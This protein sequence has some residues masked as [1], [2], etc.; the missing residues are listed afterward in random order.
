MAGKT[1]THIPWDSWKNSYETE[2]EV[3][4]HDIFRSNGQPYDQHEVDVI[5]EVTRKEEAAPYQK[6][7]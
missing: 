7:A 4:F 2:P 1:Q 6:V 3:W 5:R